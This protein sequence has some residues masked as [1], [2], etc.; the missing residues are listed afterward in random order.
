M[1]ELEDSLVFDEWAG[2]VAAT[3]SAGADSKILAGTQGHRERPKD[4]PTEDQVLTT[5]VEW[6]GIRRARRGRSRPDLLPSRDLIVELRGSPGWPRD[7]WLLF[8]LGFLP[9]AGSCDKAVPVDRP[10]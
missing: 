4:R 3:R 9:V 6:S 8:E 7:P 5:P 10:C 1:I 2:H